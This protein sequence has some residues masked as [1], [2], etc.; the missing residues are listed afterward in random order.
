M[1]E[2]TQTEN[3]VKDSNPINPVSMMLDPEMSTRA[4][5]LAKIMAECSYA[6][7]EHLRGNAGDCLAVIYQ[8]A[9]MKIDPF[10]LAQRTSIDKGRLVYKAQE[11]TQEKAQEKHR[12]QD[13]PEWPKNNERGD[14]VDSSGIPWNAEFHAQGKG[15]TSGNEWRLKR[16][17]D[18]KKLEQYRIYYNSFDE[19]KKEEVKTRETETVSPNHE[20]LI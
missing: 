1:N 15:L 19:E 10:T 7:P 12:T 3:A 13:K 20:S 17:V 18:K 16:G 4:I 5:M 14:A 11:K 9:S 6:I 2:F 8:S